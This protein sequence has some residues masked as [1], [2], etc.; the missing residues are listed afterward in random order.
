MTGFD[1]V[2]RYDIAFTLAMGVI[3][4][5]TLIMGAPLWVF[6]LLMFVTCLI[7]FIRHFDEIMWGPED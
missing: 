5:A 3:M 4:N 1:I 6:V 2:D 7:I